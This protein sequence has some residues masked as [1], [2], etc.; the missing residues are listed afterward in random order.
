MT[1]SA[2][3]VQDLE[4]RVK[5]VYRQVALQP[6]QTYHFEMGRPLAERLGYP[7]TCSTKF[8]EPLSRY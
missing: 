4:R 8:H 7:A 5:D 3:D 2:V 6:E 1:T